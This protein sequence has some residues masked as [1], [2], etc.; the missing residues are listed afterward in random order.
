MESTNKTKGAEIAPES[1]D[2]RGDSK[3][4]YA[5]D[6]VNDFTEF[7]TLSV[8]VYHKLAGDKQEVDILGEEQFVKKLIYEFY[9]ESPKVKEVIK[10]Q[11]QK[12]KDKKE[13]LF[14]GGAIQFSLDVYYNYYY[15]AVN[16]ELID[17][18]GTILMNHPGFE[19]I[20]PSVMELM[21]DRSSEFGQDSYPF[22][23][24][25]KHNLKDD[26]GLFTDIE[27]YRKL[28]GLAKKSLNQNT[29]IRRSTS[30][31]FISR[32]ESIKTKIDLLNKGYNITWFAALSEIV[33]A[34]I[35]KASK[36]TTPTL[37]A[38]MTVYLIVKMAQF[39]GFNLCKNQDEFS[40]W[41]ADIVPGDRETI[42][43]YV[44][45]F[46]KNKLDSVWKNEGLQVEKLISILD[47]VNSWAVTPS[48]D[49][50]KKHKAS[51]FKETIT[52]PPD[53]KDGQITNEYLK[54]R[55]KEI[56]GK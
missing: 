30:D 2:E 7:L 45:K 19:G 34:G 40:Q 11:I 55:Y 51:A 17:D 48:L 12:G 4:K 26:F 29:A 13:I 52:L 43:T 28:A 16:T 23:T 24:F 56:T 42:T 6:P 22:I 9:S 25:S 21:E 1:L 38:A 50:D 49:K 53:V 33:K 35:N 41:I 46:S 8:K 31:A 54:K 3:G 36:Y 44:R 20:D 10:T 5:F 14:A 39:C 27:L 47:V 15:G 37:D 32:L 18:D